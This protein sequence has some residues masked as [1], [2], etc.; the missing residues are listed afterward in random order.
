MAVKHF[1][2][3]VERYR[4]DHDG[5]DMPPIEFT[6]DAQLYYAAPVA[7]GD[8]IMHTAVIAESGTN[9]QRAMAIAE[10]L[11]TVLLPESAERIGARLRNPKDPLTAQDAGEI[12]R[13]LLEDVYGEGRPTSPSSAGSESPSADGAASTDGAPPE[14]STL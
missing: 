2:S 10:F 6:L 1:V 14:A 8:A 9:G 5:E 12:V 7:P 4:Q 11:D 13:W 3:A